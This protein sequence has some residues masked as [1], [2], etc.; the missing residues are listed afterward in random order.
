LAGSA[1]NANGTNSNARFSSPAALVVDNSTNLYVADTANHTIRKVSPSGT[2]WVASTLAGVAGA[3]G[4]AD[5]TN[6]NARL[7]WPSGIALDSGGHIFVSDSTNSTIRKIRAVG[8]NWV[9]STLA[10]LSGAIPANVDGTG[11]AARFDYPVGIATDSGGS[12]YVMDYNTFTMR[13]GKIAI[14]LQA[15]PSGNQLTLS[16]PLAGSNFV[17]EYTGSVLPV[18]SWSRL[19]NAGVAGPDNYSFTTN[20]IPPAAYFRLHK[21]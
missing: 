20:I 8:T 4:S 19:T 17:L 15:A 2:N 13:L 12:L 5:G 18:P 6:N 9:V 21:P 10:G 3:P 16:W 7:N 1:G 14:L 11:S